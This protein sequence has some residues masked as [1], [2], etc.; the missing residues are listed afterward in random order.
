[1]ADLHGGPGHLH[2][3]RVEWALALGELVRGAADPAR[4]RRRLARAGRRSREHHGGERQR[5]AHVVTPRGKTPGT[6]RVWGEPAHFTVNRT[7]SATSGFRGMW[8]QSPTTAMIRC[9]PGLRES[10]TNSVCPCPR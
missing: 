8:L 5:D 9:G 2:G 6:Q 1:V 3:R 7:V 4:E 10:R